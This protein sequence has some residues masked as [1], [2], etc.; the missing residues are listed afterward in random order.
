MPDCAFDMVL[1]ACGITGWD[2]A[3]ERVVSAGAGVEVEGA[4]GVAAVAATGGADAETTGA[5]T[6]GAD[7][8]VDAV[9]AGG[10]VEGGG[11]DAAS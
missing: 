5:E 1:A 6:G 7:E 10:G 4:R 3:V 11:T 9:D 2:G 8:E